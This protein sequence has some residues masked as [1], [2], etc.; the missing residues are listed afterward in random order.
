MMAGE[1]IISGFISK[2]IS[3]AADIPG[4]S[5]KKAIKDADKNRKDKNQSIE[6]RI[7]QVIIDSINQFTNNTYNGQDSLYDVAESILIGFIRN[8][9]DK[10]EAVRAGLKMLV[11]QVTNET[12]ENFLKVL[13]HEICIDKNDILYKEI[14]LLQGKQT[15]EAVREGF[16]VSNKN[17]E[18][19][20]E[21]LDYMIGGLDNID[22]K[23]D[24]IEKREIKHRE[25]PIANRA[26]EY[27]KKWNQNVFLNNFS[28]RDDNAGINIKL[29]DIY[30]EKYLPNYIWKA[31]MEASNDLK[32]LL[33]EYTVDNNDKKMLLILGQPGIGKSTLITW[34]MANLIEKKEDILVYQFTTDLATIDWE[35]RNVLKDIFSVIGLEYDGLENKTL[36]FDGFDEID[37][38][39]NRERILNKLNR[40]LKRLNALKAFSMIITC[41]ENYVYNLQDID[42]DYIVLQA[43]DSVQIEN[44]CGTYWEKCGNEIS[45][46]KI[47]RILV[48]K[49][50]FGVPLILYMILA[51]DIKIENVSSVVDIYDQI[52]SVKKGG[53]YD[54]CYDTEH[55]INAPEIKK[56]IHQI[57]QRI[58]FWIFEN[59]ADE[60]SIYKKNF[61]KIC[62]TM[63]LKSKDRSED[64][65]SN[66][67]IGSYFKIKHCEGELADEVNFIHRSIYEY[68]VAVYFFESICNLTSKEEVAGKLGELL[69]D[70]HLTMQMLEYIK[71]KFDCMKGY[72]LADITIKIFNEMLGKNMTYYTKVEEPYNS[73]INRERNIFSNMLEVVG[74]WNSSLGNLNYGILTYL[75]CNREKHLNLRGIQL[76]IGPNDIVGPNLSGAY[77]RE[78][79]LCGANLRGV[80]LSGANLSKANLNEANLSKAILA[81]ANLRGASLIRADLKETVF[82]E[83]QVDELCEKYNINDSRVYI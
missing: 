41:R 17:D 14:I 38:S 69:K 60:A 57:S 39:G 33:S 53:I 58:A 44:F 10:A 75:Q 34:M 52:F 55:R 47:Q 82:D 1:M 36:I 22:K 9:D 21:K 30:L 66:T 35:S 67:L 23:I 16:G 37:I 2:I 51:L 40:E 49:E 31:N 50:I 73:I 59:N 18:E 61:E 12:C 63:V 83:N 27:A 71:C 3:E 65:Q 74:L 32:M 46:D 8:K 81:T 43:W 15:F 64:I 26:E 78:A 79:D 24:G 45:V 42:C 68:F 77:L 28:E 7:Y 19:T 29:K 48:N 80:N 76:C 54:R 20:H 4:N 62:D 25:I 70:G 56:Y 11:S 72:D 5:I 13:H 6:T